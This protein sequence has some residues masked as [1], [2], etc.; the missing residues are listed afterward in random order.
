[1]ADSIQP[2]DASI[3]VVDDE[4]IVLN[5][6]EDTLTDEGYSVTTTSSAKAWSAVTPSSSLA[7]RGTRR[8]GAMWTGSLFSHGE[9]DSVS[10][11]N[12]E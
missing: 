10:D 9:S 7:S 5:L 8:A 11:G 4:Q 3:L 2:G 12:G 1:M 6:V